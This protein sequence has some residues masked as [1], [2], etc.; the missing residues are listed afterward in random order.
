[1]ADTR[2]AGQYNHEFRTVAMVAF[3]SALPL[4]GGLLS[5]H[6][7]AP[8][9]GCP[10][11]I[12][13]LLV[14]TAALAASATEVAFYRRR[15]FLT[16]YLSPDGILFRLLSGRIPMVSWQC[17]KAM[18]LAWVLLISALLFEP[19]QWWVLLADTLL[20]ALLMGLFSAMLRG[21]VKSA[22]AEP[23]ARH[24]AL[25]VNAVVLWGVLVIVQFYSAHE[26]YTGLRW[27]DVA[28]HG[29][30]RVSVDTLFQCK[31]NLPP[32]HKLD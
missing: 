14:L 7:L 27:E 4:W 18:L 3:G 9:L 29:A 5:W 2:C 6:R 21:E 30:S 12:A 24:W 28:V 23:L 20:I 8:R 11:S 13:I 25:R 17:A 10:E 19:I 32:V 31:S 1:M 16:H 22:Y 15:A 26:D